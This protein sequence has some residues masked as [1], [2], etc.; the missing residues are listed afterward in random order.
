[1]TRLSNYRFIFQWGTILG[2]CILVRLPHFLTHHFYF[3]EDEALI[4]IM[5]QDLLSG[6]AFPYYFYGQNYG[7]SIFE[8]VSVAGCIKIF[9]SGIW[10]LRIGGLLI[11]SLGVTFIYRTFKARELSGLFTCSVVFLVLAFPTWYL[12]GAMVR[13]GYVTAFAASCVIFFIT[14]RKESK[15][16]DAWLLGLMMYIAYEG[17]GLVLLPIL[18]LVL[19]WW[20]KREGKW[21]SA[22]IIPAVAL[23]SL[24]GMRHLFVIDGKSEAPP[25][26]W[27]GMKWENFTEHMEGWINGFSGFYFYGVN[28]D[29]PFYWNVGLYILFIVMIVAIVV[30]IWRA[31]LKQK[32]IATFVLLAIGIDLLL[33]AQIQEYAP[34]YFIG[35]FTGILFLLLYLFVNVEFRIKRILTAALAVT[36]FIGITT[37]SKMRRH[38]Y[39]GKN[40]ADG[41]EQVYTYAKNQKNVKAVIALDNQYAW[42][43]MFGDDIPATNLCW[44]NRTR[45]FSDRVKEVFEKD[46]DGIMMTGFYGI[47]MGI[48]ELEGFKEESIHPVPEFFVFRR[49]TRAH[50]EKG[51]ER[52]YCMD[53]L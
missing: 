40:F 24:Y 20:L 32:M 50:I 8:T 31:T 30:G 44:E 27:A 52:F 36:A 11:F 23:T 4:G 51:R 9:G 43:Y 53:E 38:W 10:A 25:I 28:F 41:L 15:N 22:L 39:E 19:D 49:V 29:P 26:S 47:S 45:Q 1:M 14:Q 7:L 16:Y 18:P 35:I 12:W 33:L 48:E 34:R 3:D 46:P 21:K 5:A 42:N 13:G 2:L 37:G 17:H 6:D